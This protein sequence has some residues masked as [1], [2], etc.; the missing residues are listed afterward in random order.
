MLTICCLA[1][2]TGCLEPRSLISPGKVASNESS[3][4]W[5]AA[6]ALA[7]SS[8]ILA[9][10]SFFRTF[11]FWPNS[12]L[13]SGAM[14]RNSSKSFVISPFLPRRRTL[15]SSISFSVLQVRFL[16]SASNC[17]ICSFIVKIQYFKNANVMIFQQSFIICPQAFSSLPPRRGSFHWTSPPWPCVSPWLS[18]SWRPRS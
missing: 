2:D 12:L 10:A 17:S 14:V 11:S 18:G 15:A 1:I 9:A 8:S 6:W 13:S 3:A 7:L 4:A 5:P 16:T